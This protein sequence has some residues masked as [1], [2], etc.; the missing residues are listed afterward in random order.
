V[1]LVLMS[2]ALVLTSTIPSPFAPLLFVLA[3][4]CITAAVVIE[5]RRWMRSPEL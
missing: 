2:S 3:G 1:V 4:V 5:M